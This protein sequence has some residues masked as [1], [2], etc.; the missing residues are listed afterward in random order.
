MLRYKN[1]TIEKYPLMLTPKEIFDFG[2]NFL[3]YNSN[4][5][6]VKVDPTKATNNYQHSLIGNVPVEALNPTPFLNAE[7]KLTNIKN[8]VAGEES[9]RSYKDAAGNY[10]LL[11]NNL[12]D[13]GQSHLL[14]LNKNI[15]IDIKSN[16]EFLFVATKDL[17]SK[18]WISK[19]SKNLDFIQSQQIS[20]LAPSTSKVSII[21]DYIFL[22]STKDFQ[23]FNLDLSVIKKITTTGFTSRS[24]VAMNNDFALGVLNSKLVKI[25]ISSG[26]ITEIHNLA[27]TFTASPIELV[28]DNKT[29]YFNMGQSKILKLELPTSVFY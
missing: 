5:Q 11:N 3:I 14:G 13:I 22:S 23:I 17:A 4:N 26:E 10:W 28:L 20:S 15:I 25:K 18:F 6:A 2:P 9:Y 21:N 8:S 19:Y 27:G 24:F 16:S 29:L 7:A 1:A 12:I